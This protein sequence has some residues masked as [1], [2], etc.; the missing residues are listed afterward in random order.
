MD[1]ELRVLAHE[2]FGLLSEY[3][4][5][6]N[7]MIG[8]KWFAWLRKIDFGANSRR[9]AEVGAGLDASRQQAVLLQQRPDALSRHREYIA[10]MV[11]YIR[12]L[13]HTV[14]MLGLVAARLGQQAKGAD[15]YD[16]TEYRQE[17]ETYRASVERYTEAGHML[18]AAWNK[19]G[20]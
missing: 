16:I 18:V 4:E 13:S 2:V 17:M 10:A 19:A 9:L 14:A 3:I 12:E 6:H 5:V 8:R 20:L 1:D 7:D 15:R 11:S